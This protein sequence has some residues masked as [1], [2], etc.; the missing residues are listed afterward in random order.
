MGISVEATPNPAAMKFTVGVAV[1]GP[2]TY[3]D[4][5]AADEPF[6]SIL[7]EDGVA[8]V[9]ATADFITVTKS[10][11]GEWDTLRPAIVTI[12]EGAFS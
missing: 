11:E 10:P 5:S 8:S 7:N 4:A 6:A 12:L 3:A 2:A 9:F 1:G